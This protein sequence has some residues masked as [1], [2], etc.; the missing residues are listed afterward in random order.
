MSDAP[1]S[2]KNGPGP[3]KSV[4][5]PTT[6]AR[7]LRERVNFF[8]KVWTGIEKH[9]GS[10]EI[11]IDVAEFERKIEEE[12]KK[13]G[14][15]LLEFITLR[16]TP[17]SSPK[18]YQTEPKEQVVLRKTHE[19]KVVVP[20]EHETTYKFEYPVLRRTQVEVGESSISKEHVT[21]RKTPLSSPKRVVET[22]TWKEKPINI[23]QIERKLAEE[24]QKNIEHTQLERIQLK[25]TRK[26]QDD[27]R[28]HLESWVPKQSDNFEEI[29]ERTTEE[30]DYSSGSKM[31]KFEKI[32]VKKST[33]EILKPLGSRTPSEERLLEDSA[34]HSHG[35]GVSKSSSISSLTGR[36]PSE[37]NLRRTPSRENLGK[38]EWDS[39]SSSSKHTTSGSEWYNEYKHQS[40]LQSGTK[41]DFV[42]S[43]SQYDS[44]IA[45]IR[46]KIKIY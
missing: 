13:K 22:I 42:R 14:G 27:E 41:L 45:E 1:N 26:D 21:L 6:Q 35:N 12:K 8:E 39:G 2:D 34:Y 23:T 18:H 46:G 38:D 29:Y 32:I 37:E 24:R 43:K 5:S 19:E 11:G 44:H 9:E 3:S 30:G 17:P 7:K 25:P 28:K 20:I 16:S 40:F 31:V 4:D 10:E 33:K 15:K 36:F